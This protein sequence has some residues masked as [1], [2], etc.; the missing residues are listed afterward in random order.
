M[1]VNQQKSPKL[2]YKE[3]KYRINKATTSKKQTSESC[4]TAL[5]FK[6]RTTA[7]PK[8]KTEDGAEGICEVI[9]VNNPQKLMTDTKPQI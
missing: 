7:K 4:G 8:E 1:K 3:E 2:K 9:P 5:T 6:T